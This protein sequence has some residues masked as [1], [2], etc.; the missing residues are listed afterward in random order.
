[1][2]GW[3]GAAGEVQLARCGWQGAASEVQLARHKVQL[4]YSSWWGAAQT[5]WRR[6][7]HDAFHGLE[8]SYTPLSA[9]NTLAR[10]ILMSL[11]VKGS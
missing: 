11:K 8:H 2:C 1:M 5:A 6:P 3:R 7:M 10:F 9:A 4:L